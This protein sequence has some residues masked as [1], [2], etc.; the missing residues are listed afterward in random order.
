MDLK[1]EVF[2]HVYPP[3]TDT[4]LLLDFVHPKPND[5]VLE[6]CTGCGI[7]ALHLAQIVKQVVATDLNPHAVANA[8]HNTRVNTLT[9][10]SI[11]RGDLYQPVANQRFNLIVANPPYV[12]TPPEWRA[13]DAIEMSWNA[14]YDGRLLIDRILDGLPDYLLPSGRF[15]MVQSSLANI[16]KTQARLFALG[17]ECHVLAK[18]W[19]PLGPVSLG[20]YDWLLQR[21]LLKNRSAEL[22]VVLQ[23]SLRNRTL[24]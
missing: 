5:V 1:I 2:P 6:L 19:L 9:N 18:K 12:P 7:L 20:R 15:V 10:V 13:K 3:Q 14:G 24:V 17:F 4:F 21:Q 16:K 11:Q 23:A 22:L 8:R